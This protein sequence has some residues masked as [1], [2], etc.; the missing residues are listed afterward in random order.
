MDITECR[1]RTV[2]LVNTSSPIRDNVTPPPSHPR[3]TA[4]D[5][6]APRDRHTPSD[7]N[8]PKERITAVKGRTST[9]ILET[10]VDHVNTQ[11]RVFPNRRVWGPERSTPAQHAPSYYPPSGLVTRSGLYSSVPYK[12]SPPAI[13]KS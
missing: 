8:T 9:E 13:D 11:R 1:E 12:R 3:Y 7:G 4:E 2:A 5:G 6:H 10:T